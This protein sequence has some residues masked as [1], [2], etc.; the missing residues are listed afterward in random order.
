MDPEE[1][2]NATT[3]RRFLESWFDGDFDTWTAL[4]ADDIVV[5]MQDS[6][7]LRGTYRG[8]A[9][10]RGVLEKFAALGIESADIDVE[11]VLADERFAMAVMRISFQRGSESLDL[12]NACAYRFDAD[13]RVSETWNVSDSQGP[14][15]EFLT[16]ADAHPS[17]LGVGLGP[18]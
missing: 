14:H 15:R 8:Q 11:D 16:V 2:P 4:A 13:G 1:H 3:V 6:P 7:A 12:R 18:S 5:H 10:V 9:G 17:G